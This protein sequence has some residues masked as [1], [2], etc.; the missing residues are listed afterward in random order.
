MEKDLQ[1]EKELVLS[2][3]DLNRVQRVME[4]LNWGYYDSDTPPSKERLSETVIRLIDGSIKDFERSGE[5][6]ENSGGGFKV[7]IDEREELWVTFEI[8]IIT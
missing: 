2:M 6:V 5:R 3:L 1:N 7:T 4:L 8:S